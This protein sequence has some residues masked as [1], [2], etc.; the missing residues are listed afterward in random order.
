MS[1]TCVPLAYL[2]SRYPAISHTFILREIAHLRTLGHQIHTASINA[3]DRSLDAMDAT[4]RAEAERGGHVDPGQG[5]LQRVDQPGAGRQP[6]QR[7]RLDERVERGRRS[8][9]QRERGL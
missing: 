4:E 2:V 3:P 1:N 9:Q 8:A 6:R 5:G 7:L